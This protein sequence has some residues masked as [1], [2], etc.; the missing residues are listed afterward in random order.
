ME[1]HA[2]ARRMEERE[3]RAQDEAL[4]REREREE[5]MRSREARAGRRGV[6]DGETTES[7]V[8]LFLL[9]GSG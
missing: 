9:L 5:K 8:S 7:G 4:R 3:R 2:R 6:W 1:L